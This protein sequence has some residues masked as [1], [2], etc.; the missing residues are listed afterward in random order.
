MCCD[1]ITT[2]DETNHNLFVR[3]IEAKNQ[4]IYNGCLVAAHAIIF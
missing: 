3:K 2:H 4:Q 1:A